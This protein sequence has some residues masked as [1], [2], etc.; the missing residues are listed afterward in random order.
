MHF[1]T[2]D[3]DWIDKTLTILKSKF[4]SS[5]FTSG[6]ATE[7]LSRKKDY[8]KG[9]TY[10]ILHELTIRGALTRLGQGRYRFPTAHSVSLSNSFTISDSVPD[11]FLP[12]ANENIKKVLE[13]IGLKFM[14]TGP[15]LLYPFIHHFPRRMIQLIYV[16][17]GGGETA[18]EALKKEGFHCLLKPSRAEVKFA[19]HEFDEQDILVIRE[20]SNFEGEV[21][22]VADL[23]R[24]LVD[25]YFEATRNKI[26]FP[27]EEFGR[28]ISKIIERKKVNIS[29]LLKLAGRRTI[30]PEFRTIIEHIISDLNIQGPHSE[31][32]YV[33]A[34]ILGINSEKR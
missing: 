16:I 17:K 8:S 22:G 11:K 34:V 6:N 3:V 14:I 13:K 28:M 32:E 15:S 18:Q 24:A 29:H 10:K 4:K 7:L 9:T 30:K 25:T 27:P 26:S 12:K 5:A 2:N 1:L 31:N 20:V 33:K 21:D 19:L 23:E